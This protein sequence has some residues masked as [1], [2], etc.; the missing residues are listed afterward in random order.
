MAPVSRFQTAQGLQA[1][2]LAADR[3]RV[4]LESRRHPGPVLAGDPAHYLRRNP[5][6]ESTSKDD[7]VPYGMQTHEDV[8][9]TA[10][11]KD[12]LGGMHERA[13]R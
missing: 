12:P 13:L 2:S 4:A 1:L 9:A 8:G 11:E 3:S 10:I 6:P 5:R 7:G